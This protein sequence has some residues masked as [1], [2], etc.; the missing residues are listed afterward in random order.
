MDPLIYKH[1]SSL[2]HISVS[3]RVQCNWYKLHLFLII[4][5]ISR[6]CP[7][8]RI[9]FNTTVPSI[10]TITD[11][12]NELQ[13]CHVCSSQYIREKKKRKRGGVSLDYKK[14]SG[15]TQYRAKQKTQK[16]MTTFHFPLLLK[17]QIQRKQKKKNGDKLRAP[18]LAYPVLVN[19]TTIVINTTQNIL[20]TTH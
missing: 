7:L 9:Q 12:H 6:S 15:W 8:T 10:I 4:H 18:R 14:I 16:W 1:V 5:Q 19:F 2:G 11:H 13:Y 3:Q 20:S 17:T